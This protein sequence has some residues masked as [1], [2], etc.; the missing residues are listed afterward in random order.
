M[1]EHSDIQQNIKDT[2]YAATSAKGDAVIYV[3]NYTYNYK[4][5][6]DKLSISD[7]DDSENNIPC[8]YRGL[9]SFSPNDA[10]FFFGRDVF[11]EQLYK[12]T[13]TNNFI[14]V[15]GASGSGKSSVVLAGL[16]PKLERTGKWKFAHFRPGDEPFHALAKA[17]LSLYQPDLNETEQLKQS[18]K[19]AGYFIEG[20]VLLKDVFAQIESNYPNYRVL[21][22]ADQFEELFTLCSN[23]KVR[24]GFLDL[25]LACFQSPPQNLQLPPVLVATMRADF[26]GNALAYRPL[27]DILNADIKLGA[28]NWEELLEVIEKPAAIL[29]VELEPG[30]ADR[31]LDDV[32]NEPGNLALLEFALTE[33]WQERTGSQLTHDAY[34]KIEKVEGALAK[35]A[36]EEYQKLS[37]QEQEQAR[38]IFIQLVNL[39]EDNNNTRRLVNRSQIGD[40]NWDLVTRKGGLADSRLVVTS[41]SNNDRET[42][43]I[44][45][46]A[47]I[48]HWSRLQ[49]WLNQ[50]RL[51]LDKQ[52]QIENAAGEW[53]KSGKNK[54][55]LLSNKRLR[56]A[57]EF[58]KEQQENYPLSD[59]AESFVSNSKKHQRNQ[60]IK[61]LGL[62]LIIPLIGTAIGIPFVIREINLNADK[63]LIRGCYGEEQ[64]NGRIQALERLVKAEK[65][66]RVYDLTGANLTRAELKG[67]NLSDAKLEG[68]NLTRAELEDANLSDAELE[69]AKLEGANLK[70]AN[71]KFAE[72]TGAILKY[73]ILEGVSLHEAELEGANLEFAEL[74]GAILM[75]TNLKRASLKRANLNRANLLGAEFN[76]A[77]LN[78][79]LLLGANLTHANLINVENITFKQIISACNWEQAKYKSK[80]SEQTGKW[81]VDE[82]ANQE[83]IKEVRR[84]PFYDFI[85]KDDCSR[86][87]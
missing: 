57:K 67:A 83:F 72:L 82:K 53:D 55:Y 22:I 48:R 54:D 70:R 61:Y 32:E 23:E 39:G 9:F 16:V 77:N 37:P 76:Q 63:R 13:E 3:Y 56:E 21:L 64:C 80:Q 20:S 50:D 27:A 29:G 51:N 86:W 46:E 44:V 6:E 28:M 87:E 74:T 31:I 35:Y 58:Q 25:L 75:G 41:R 24:Q 17:L 49:G 34:E 78:N 1:S 71:L 59:L 47:L 62:F 8:P 36:E 66:L 2:E 5:P 19:L 42:L 15:L 12:A 68:A 4:N 26:L 40:A 10:K 14:P 45:H 79:A 30:L 81:L 18:R 7:K 65:S 84:E 60:R 43:E 38:Q 85:N 73:A 69:G 11:I 52:R 33:L